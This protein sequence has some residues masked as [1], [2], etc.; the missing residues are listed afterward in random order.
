M[1]T[2]IFCLGSEMLATGCM[3]LNNRSAVPARHDLPADGHPPQLDARAS[4]FEP[5]KRVATSAAR[6]NS[7]C[8]GLRA[9][10]RTGHVLVSLEILHRALML[11]GSRTRFESAQ[12]AALSRFRAYLAG[13]E[14]VLT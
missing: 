13:I 14:P 8:L 3:G 2:D 4:R 10:P 5:R 7:S 11:L 6:K 1:I 9:G 12:I